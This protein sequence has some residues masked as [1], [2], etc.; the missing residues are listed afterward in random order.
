[1][2]VIKVREDMKA[3]G[4]ESPDL[5]DFV[6]Q[7]KSNEASDINNSGFDEQFAFLVDACGVDWIIETFLAEEAE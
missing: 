1:M 7:V 2:N 6:R 4:Y 3:R 5:D